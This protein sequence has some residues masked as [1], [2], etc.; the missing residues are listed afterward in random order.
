[1]S[2]PRKS[3]KKFDLVEGPG[4]GLGVIISDQFTAHFFDSCIASQAAGIPFNITDPKSYDIELDDVVL[5][6]IF[7][8]I[9]KGARA[10]SL[11]SLR[12]ADTSIYAATRY[13]DAATNVTRGILSVKK[14][15][16]DIWKRDK[17]EREKAICN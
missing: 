14:F 2:E 8:P 16:E 11:A 6:E 9:H 13:F 1:M 7:F 3:P 17:E 12:Q 15:A 10:H 5:V 4:F